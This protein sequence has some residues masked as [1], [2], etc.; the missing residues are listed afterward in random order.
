M[1]KATIKSKTGAL[2]TV[3]GSEKEVS[4]ILS[5]FERTAAVGQAKVAIARGRAEKKEQ[6]KRASVSDLVV[7]LKE[8][9]FFDKP[10]GL[11]DISNALEEQ[12]YICP[13]TTLSAVMLGLVKKRLFRRKKADGKWVYG[14]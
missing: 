14:K 5:T 6:K 10:K 4:D 9:G 13:V 2:I 12:G 7:T 3:E 8:D 1:A 11:S